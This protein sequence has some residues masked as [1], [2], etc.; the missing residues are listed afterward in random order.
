MAEIDV[1][2]IDCG[3]GHGEQQSDGQGD[4]GDGLTVLLV[5]QGRPETPAEKT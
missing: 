5:A 3:S 1:A 2:D 4:D